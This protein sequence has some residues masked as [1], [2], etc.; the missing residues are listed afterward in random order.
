M[1]RDEE[2]YELAINFPEKENGAESFDEM[3]NSQE[4]KFL[5]LKDISSQTQQVSHT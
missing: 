2:V 4:S 1:G 5:K 3:I